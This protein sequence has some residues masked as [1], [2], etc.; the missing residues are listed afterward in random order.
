M[1][2]YVYEQTIKKEYNVMPCPCC[3][4]EDSE[5]YDFVYFFTT[6]K[7]QIVLKALGENGRK[8]YDEAVRLTRK[9]REGIRNADTR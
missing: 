1:P 4:G 5:F 2:K 7:G 8:I 3:L 9:A 6:F